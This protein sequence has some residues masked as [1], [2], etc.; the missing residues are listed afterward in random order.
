MP[1]CTFYNFVQD[2]IIKVRIFNKQKLHSK[3]YLFTR[4]LPKEYG[5]LSDNRA[6]FRSSNLS[7]SGLEKNAELNANFQ[8]KE[9]FEWLSEY[10]HKLW[11]QSNEYNDEILKIIEGTPRFQAYRAE[12][13][14]RYLF[15]RDFTIQEIL[16]WN[17]DYLMEERKELLP[18]QKIDY[19]N[20]KR[21]PDTYKGVVIA[22]SVGLGK[23][24]IACQLMID[25]LNENKTVL[26]IIP[27]GIQ[28]QWETYLRDFRN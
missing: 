26:L 22:S 10:F 28:K 19:Q 11:I 14:W 18:F 6:I 21:I 2:G 20:A 24:Y 27:P 5:N 1:S 3:L 12:R 23:S 13:I 17:K 16:N 25:F 8:D 4:P 7:D 15:P 9:D